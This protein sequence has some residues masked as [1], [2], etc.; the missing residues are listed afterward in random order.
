MPIA[1]DPQEFNQEE[2]Y[3]DL[4]PMFGYSLF[5]KVEGFNFANSIKLEGSGAELAAPKRHR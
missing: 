4:R 5:L 2:L 1:T 3:V